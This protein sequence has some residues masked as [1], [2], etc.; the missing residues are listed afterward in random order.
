MNRYNAAALN[1][2]VGAALVLA[3]LS[4]A[5]ADQRSHGGHWGSGGHARVS[6]GGHGGYGYGHGYGAW[7]VFGL[8][9]AVVGA[10]AAIVTA[11]IA[12]LAAAANAPYY[13]P[14]LGY[15][16]PPVAY[17]DAS[18][19][20]YPAPAAPAYYPPAASSY[21]APAAPAY[22][23]PPA[24]PI[25]RRL[26]PPLIMLRLPAPITLRLPA[27]ITPPRPPRTTTGARRTTRRVRCNTDRRPVIRVNR[28]RLRSTTTKIRVECVADDTIGA[29]RFRTTHST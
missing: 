15:A 6:Y 7:P 5:Y 8:A 16:A 1:S 9:A 18:P 26:H 3:P 2:I 17:G 28:H 12:L 4:S 27:R 20:Y 14:A 25:T 24:P 21:Y 29:Q 23:A 13:G 19:A 11:P 22:Y 10:A